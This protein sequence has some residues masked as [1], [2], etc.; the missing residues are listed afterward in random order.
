MRIYGTYAPNDRQN[1]AGGSFVCVMRNGDRLVAS[2]FAHHMA[3][4]RQRITVS[5]PRRPANEM[6]FLRQIPF[7]HLPLSLPPFFRA[8]WKKGEKLES[9][10][11]VARARFASNYRTS[12]AQLSRDA[13]LKHFASSTRVS[14]LCVLTFILIK[15]LIIWQIKRINKYLSKFE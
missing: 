10:L 15:S 12:A 13:N 6:P 5:M 2:W 3:S 9:G 14:I 11:S 1:D 7:F 8:D 4:A